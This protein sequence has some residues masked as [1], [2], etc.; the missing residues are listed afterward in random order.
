MTFLPLRMRFGVFMAPFH[1]L[2]ENVTLSLERDMQLVEH[3]DRPVAPR[4][5]PI[6]LP[7]VAH[8]PYLIAAT[9]SSRSRLISV[10]P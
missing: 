9:A 6:R 1:G 3:L 7:G 10:A 4:Q 8:A 2:A 5:H